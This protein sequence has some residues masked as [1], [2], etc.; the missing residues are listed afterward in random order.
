MVGK[1]HEIQIAQDKSE[2][3]CQPFK[4]KKKTVC[5]PSLVALELLPNHCAAHVLGISNEGPRPPLT[6]SDLNR[7]PFPC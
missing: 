4:K 7:R 2:N 5:F 6:S 1:A 3:R